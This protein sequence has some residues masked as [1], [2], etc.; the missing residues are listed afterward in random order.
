MEGGLDGG[1]SERRKC[2]EEKVRRERP[3]AKA[4]GTRQNNPLAEAWVRQSQPT[5]TDTSVPP[6]QSAAEPGSAGLAVGNCC[7]ER[8]DGQ[9]T[10]L[11]AILQHG[12]FAYA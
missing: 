11:P 7:W 5:L 10:L 12:R 6:A 1:G 2:G 3:P 4:R 8:E 9:E